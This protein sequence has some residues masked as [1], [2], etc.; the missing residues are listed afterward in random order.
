MRIEFWPRLARVVGVTTAAGL[1]V[2]LWVTEAPA[3]GSSPGEDPVM[4]PPFTITDQRELPKLE[5]WRYAKVGN[6]ELLTNA[7]AQES[8][9]LFN[10]FLR[11]H[12]ALELIRPVALET[13]GTVAFVFC[14]KGDGLAEFTKD[15]ERDY[16]G[17]ASLLYYDQQQSCIVVDLDMRYLEPHDIDQLT[18][19]MPTAMLSGFA[20]FEVEP[21]RQL[22]REFT[23]LLYARSPWTPPP[24]LLEGLTQIMM[25][26][27]ISNRSIRYGRLNPSQGAPLD[28]SGA[29]EDVTGISAGMSAGDMI[30]SLIRDRNRL[31][32]VGVPFERGISETNQQETVIGD[33]P[34]YFVLANRPLLP[35]AEFFAVTA[36]DPRARIP[37]A[38]S[39]WA[40]QAYAFVHL[41]QFGANGKFKQ[42]FEQLVE[43][44]GKEP[45]S[46]PLFEECFGLTY[47]Q[48]LDELSFY[49]TY[50]R[51][52]YRD[53]KLAKG[54]ELKV[55]PVP[56]R[57]ATQAEIARIKGDAQRMAG[58]RADALFTYRVAYARGERDPALLAALG[59]A[60]FEAGEIDRARKFLEAAAKL[61]TARPAAW[62]TLARLRLDACKQISAA[63][64]GKLS[65]AQMAEVFAPLLQARSLEPALPETYH[66]MAEAWEQ[67]AE[68]P[69]P[70][71]VHLVGEGAMYFPTDAELV[72]RTAQLYAKAGDL[73]N[74]GEVA[75]MALRFASDDATRDRC[76]RFLDSL[77]V[78]P[79]IRAVP[80]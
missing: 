65:T 56:L 40:K 71:Q 12:E 38:N 46:E 26:I 13:G 77:A 9:R 28:V 18:G 20:R 3:F 69:N 34:F 5:S 62:T 15:G 51:H 63:G 17:G 64:S 1:G 37:L 6:F 7:A 4:L 45:I 25:D 43:R 49:V 68:L 16:S 32:Q 60:E 76:G 58:R 53:I 47:Q 27:E 78:P 50:P 54:H 42:P 66:I 35:L 59:V 61:G 55:E 8:T 57:E 70:T 10:E 36:E 73:Q 72:F 2:L 21:R 11:F 14:G 80:R 39:L 41:C 75:R 48:M 23:R 74:A 24:W 22:Y 67:S 31:N 30:T 79:P 44:L 52:V 19:N 33:R 29:S